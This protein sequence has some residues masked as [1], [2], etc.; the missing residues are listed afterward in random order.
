M[1]S[2][3]AF[4]GPAA[5]LVAV[6][7][8]YPAY[9][10]YTA[11]IAQSLVLDWVKAQRADGY[12]VRH[13]PLE[14][15]GFPFVVRLTVPD[16]S[17]E[18]PSQGWTWRSHDLTLELPPWDLQRIRFEIAGQQRLR[19]QPKPRKEDFTFQVGA[20]AGVAQIGGDGELRALSV[21]LRE[22]RV[23]EAEAGGMFQTDRLLADL[24]RPDHPAISHTER[25]LGVSV[26][27]ENTAISQID[28][29]PLGSRI[30]IVQASADIFGPIHGESLA[31]A[32]ESWRQAGGTLEI[33][34]LNLVWG[35]LDLRANGTA[36]LDET[37]RPL[38]ALT[39]DIRGYEETLEALAEA[40]LVRRDMLP[41]SR[42]TLNLLAR[43]DTT[44]GRR[45]LTI[46]LTAQDG[47]LF[48]G[49]IRLTGLPALLS[50]PASRPSVPSG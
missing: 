48:L 37:L 15:S 44:D 24:S 9:W 19:I 22:L 28:A 23:T 38:G 27:L 8:G 46:P 13:G 36:A 49:P 21:D 2:P 7:I 18:H 41:A 43:K 42:V 30:A 39:A 35:A 3:R 47:A 26:R 32:V 4:I 5:F 34:W 10:Y 29:R 17:A 1:I 50:S 33:N 45:V 12:T 31:Q 16:P 25:S 14:T 6:L 20:A 11:G 40:G